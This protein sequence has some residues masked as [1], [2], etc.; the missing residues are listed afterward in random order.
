[1]VE[2]I[3][4]AWGPGGLNRHTAEAAV[5]NIA[6]TMEADGWERA[7]APLVMDMGQSGVVSLTVK[8]EE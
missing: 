2:T 6:R 5:E 4:R 3:T 8:K 7:G 1:M